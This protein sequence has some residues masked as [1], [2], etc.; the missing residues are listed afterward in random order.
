MAQAYTPG[1][2]VASR[3]TH[4][5]RRVLPI[6]GDVL[7]RQGDTVAARDVVAQT[8]MPGDVT[9]LNMANLLSAQAGDVPAFMLKKVGETVAVGEAIARTKGIFGMFKAE[10]R[11][12]TAGTVESVSGTTGQVI[13]RGEPL[14]VR[15]EAYLAGRVIEVLPREGC[16]IESEVALVQG[17][18]GIGGEA[19]GPLRLACQS[20]EEELADDLIKPEMKGSIVVGGARVTEA[21]IRK[22]VQAGVAA[23]VTG[24]IDDQDLK[25]FLGYDLGVAITGSERVGLTI[26]IT[27]GFGEIAMAQRTYKLLASHQGRAAAV[28]GATQIRAGVMRPEVLIPLAAAPEKGEGG[29]RPP[30]GLLEI[31]RA[32]RVIRDPYFGLIGAVSGLPPEPQVLGSGSKARVLEVKFESGQRVVIPRANVELIEG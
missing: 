22:A 26:V 21:A 9:P 28:N 3:T 20:H 30:D 1:L 24:G 12:K 27:E 18:F 31:G 32:V 8:F 2:K 7:V 15:V 29:G 6:H 16:V 17:I 25:N 14:P 10:Y 13:L 23:I 19:H 5:V 4:R 11:S